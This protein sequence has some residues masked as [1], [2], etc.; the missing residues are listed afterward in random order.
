MG[1][2]RG[3]AVNGKLQLGVLA[4]IDRE[5]LHQQGDEPRTSSTTKAGE[6]QEALKTCALLSQFPNSVQV[7]VNDLLA[8]G[9]ASTGIVIGS[10]F[11]ACGQLLRVEKVVAGASANFSD[12]CGLQ[13]CKQC[14]QH[15]LA[16]TCLTE[17]G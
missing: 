2:T 11:L 9:V 14:P 6:N 3:A 7:E 15:M 1:L 12:D 10:I 8:N 5:T 16:S 17:E 13:V 4:I